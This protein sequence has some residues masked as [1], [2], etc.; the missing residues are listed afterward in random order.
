MELARNAAARLPN[1]ADA[2]DTLGWIAFRAGRFG[3][4][5]SELERA[6]ALNGSE[7][8]VPRHLAE[9][10]K[11]IEEQAIAEKKAAA[12]QM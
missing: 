5:A 11:A 9:V 4:A 12:R 7:P 1:D 3:L 10:R 2:H 6:V 8:I